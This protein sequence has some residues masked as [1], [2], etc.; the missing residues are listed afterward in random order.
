MAPDA[1]KGTLSA[2]DA[3]QAIARAIRDA[4]PDALVEVLPL[5]DGGDG[6]VAALAAAGYEQRAIATRG[7]TGVPTVARVARRGGTAVVEIASACGIALLGAD[8][9]AP[10]TS[11]SLGLG[12]AV[13]AVLDDDPD[14]IVLGL[15]GS[16]STDGG[17]GLLVALGA[18]LLDAD[19][20]PVPPGGAGLARIARLDLTGLDPRLRGRRVV[21]AADVRSPL[22]GPDGAAAAFGPQ[23]GATPEQVVSLEDGLAAWAGVLADATGVDVRSA[24]GAGAAGG[25][26]AAAIAAL[27]A[28]Q[29]SGAGFV[30]GALGLADRIREADLVIT[31]EG[32]LDRTSLLG[33][34]LGDVARLSSAAG[35]P[36]LAVCGQVALSPDEASAAG[37]RRAVALVDVVGAAAATTD[38]AGSLAAA[39]RMAVDAGRAFA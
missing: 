36:V 30:H 35:V 32:R 12:D 38:P 17:T 19:D 25:C 33:K 27:G 18:R 3:A 13:C 31:G 15:G 4:T 20:V 10:M 24:P 14:E 6:T 23:K 26:G 34:G 22:L 2:N 7:P 1:F 39:V 37:I 29:V 16:A 9:L 28:V 5:A 21:V 8:R 11:T